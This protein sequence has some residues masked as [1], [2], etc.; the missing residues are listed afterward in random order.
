MAANMPGFRCD[1]FQVSDLEQPIVLVFLMK[2][3]SSCYHVPVFLTR[4]CHLHVPLAYYMLSVFL[5]YYV[6]FLSVRVLLSCIWL[7]FVFSVLL[8]YLFCFC[9]FSVVV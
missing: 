4:S 8:F 9:L 7:S 1:I 3:P 5:Y 6:F 2:I